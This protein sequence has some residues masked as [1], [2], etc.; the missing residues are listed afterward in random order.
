MRVRYRPLAERRPPTSSLHRCVPDHLLDRTAHAGS[1]LGYYWPR[2]ERARKRGLTDD[3]MSWSYRCEIRFWSIAWVLAGVVAV[4]H[5][6]S[7]G[8]ALAYFV[9]IAVVRGIA[10]LRDPDPDPTSPR[11]W[12]LKTSQFGYGVADS[13]RWAVQLLAQL[14]LQLYEAVFVPSV[15]VNQEKRARG[16]DQDASQDAKSRPPLVASSRRALY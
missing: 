5:A 6:G 15:P 8:T 14:P 2:Y 1:V 9:A 10:E 13:F 7:W 12:W 16:S 11:D 4:L 3:Y